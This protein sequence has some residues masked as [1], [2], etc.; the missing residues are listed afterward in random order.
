MKGGYDGGELA[1]EFAD[2]KASFRTLATKY[3]L[4][5]AEV[6]KLTVQDVIDSKQIAHLEEIAAMRSRKVQKRAED[7]DASSFEELLPDEVP[8]KSLREKKP[9]LTLEELDGGDMRMSLFMPPY[10]MDD[11]KAGYKQKFTLFFS[12]R[13]LEQMKSKFAAHNSVVVY[14]DGACTGNPGPSA[15][16]ACFF[17]RTVSRNEFYREDQQEQ[18]LLATESD[19]DRDEEGGFS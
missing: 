8:L 11:L 6:A 1:S 13:K 5:E 19:S 18:T 9:Y 16:A 7:S 10:D 15:A 17:G 3:N 2:L 4:T 14:I 12:K